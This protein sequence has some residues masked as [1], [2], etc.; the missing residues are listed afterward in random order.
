MKIPCLLLVFGAA[1][2]ATAP[3]PGPANVSTLEKG[4][5]AK[6]TPSSKIK[7]LIVDG[8]SNH[9]WKK[10]T[11]LLKGFLEPT[12]LFD[13]S[14]STTPPPKSAEG[15][16]TWRPKFKD[17]DVVIQT[18]NDISNSGPMWPQAVMT[19]FENYVR[20]GGGVY[21]YHGA[22]NAFA[23]WPAYNDIIGL[24]WRPVTYGTA[25]SI[26][27]NEKLVLHPP[28][29]G[30][31]TSHAPKGDVVIHLL[32]NH[33]IHEGM[34]KAWM[35]P[36]L[37]V[38]Y[39]AR[40]PAQKM[41]VLSYAKDPRFGENWP[42]E[43]IVTYG[44]GHAYISTFGHVWADDVDPESMRCVGVR[45]TIIRVLQWLAKRPV[46]WP[47]PKNFPTATEKSIVP[48]AMK[49]TA[50]NPPASTVNPQAKP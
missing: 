23:K 21:I 49:P 14:V 34:P 13:I 47:I 30:K 5:G 3:G 19:D 40:G 4:P 25:I 22:Q 35:T 50:A 43:W 29:E 11:D 15:W 17:Y 16:D 37:E 39:Y 32:G 48:T 41:E 38:Y 36:A 18:C 42:I 46:T 8:F 45:T 9:D 12:G 1:L 2:A 24:G 33:P 44:K 26:D 20:D 6:N 31:A 28:G 27:A 7:V 10:T